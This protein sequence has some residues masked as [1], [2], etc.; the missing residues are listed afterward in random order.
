M[1]V[2]ALATAR[3][4]RSARQHHQRAPK[5]NGQPAKTK[6]P[7]TAKLS[8]EFSSVERQCTRPGSG[9]LL[10]LLTL[11]ALFAHF[12]GGFSALEGPARTLKAHRA[13]KA[14][15]STQTSAQKAQKG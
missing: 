6:P 2:P 9:T 11:F 1:A 8:M 3:S 10:T 15:T 5:L 12:L 14:H 13:L 4:C 7:H